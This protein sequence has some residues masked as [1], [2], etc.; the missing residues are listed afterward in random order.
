MRK[1]SKTII[2]LAAALVGVAALSGVV[3]ANSED[4]LKKEIT[5]E[6]GDLEIEFEKGYD[7]VSD[8]KQ[9]YYWTTGKIAVDELPEGTV[10][11]LAEGY[12]FEIDA[13]EGR[14][15]EP[16]ELLDAPITA[17][18]TT[19]ESIEDLEDYKYVEFIIAK[20]GASE[21]ISDLKKS[22]IEDIFVITVPEHE[23]MVWFW[24][25]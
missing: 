8:S 1:R 18:S 11:T 2:G 22:D 19:I 21:D 3:G 16:E 23:A 12:Q 24:Q 15:K 5:I 10:I 13:Y 25:D 17:A 20:E 6:E 7:E 4:L 9:D 14:F